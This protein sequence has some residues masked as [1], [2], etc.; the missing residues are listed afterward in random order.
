MLEPAM[1]HAIQKWPYAAEDK[2]NDTSAITNLRLPA[3]APN[4][5]SGSFSM[6][7]F[8]SCF[9]TFFRMY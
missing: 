1:N 4:D 3:L 9:C 8:G 5:V 7:Y 6:N 2:S